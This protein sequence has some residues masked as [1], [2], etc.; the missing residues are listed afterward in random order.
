MLYSVNSPQYGLWG[1]QSPPSII[2]THNPG[3]LTPPE[4]T[5]SWAVR[6][7]YSELWSESSGLRVRGWW[8]VLWRGSNRSSNFQSP[9]VAAVAMAVARSASSSA[10]SRA[11]CGVLCSA[12]VSSCHCPWRVILKWLWL[13]SPLR[14]GGRDRSNLDLMEQV[15]EK[16]KGS[17]TRRNRWM[18]DEQKEI[19]TTSNSSLLNE[20]NLKWVAQPISEFITCQR[21]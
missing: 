21:R 2:K 10:G 1:R 20:W 12:L 13:C 4:P 16:S 11:R 8:R 19:T 15:P 7:T 3:L 9:G 14:Q 17:V 6:C 5:C 18:L